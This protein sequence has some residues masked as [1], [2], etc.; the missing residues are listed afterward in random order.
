MAAAI[1]SFAELLV[2]T[3]ALIVCGQG[4]LADVAG[5]HAWSLLGTANWRTNWGFR[6]TCSARRSG[7]LAGAELQEF[8]RL[9]L[10]RVRSSACGRTAVGGPL[11]QSLCA[12]S[13]GDDRHR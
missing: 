9:A 3:D 7:R 11:L 10:P 13:G 5:A 1:D 8:A 12:G 6:Y 2:D 4:T